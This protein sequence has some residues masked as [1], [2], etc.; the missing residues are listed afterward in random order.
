MYIGARYNDKIKLPKVETV[1]L[2]FG[3]TD[4]KGEQ[5][6]FIKTGSWSKWQRLIV[7]AIF[8]E[9]RDKVSLLQKPIGEKV[10]CFKEVLLSDEDHGNTLEI[11][12]HLAA[13]QY[14][15]SSVLSSLRFFPPHMP[16]SV[17][18][19]RGLRV[20]IYSRKDSRRRRLLN[21]D[22]VAEHLRNH[23]HIVTVIHTL[24]NL[25][26]IQQIAV[27]AY[28]DV[29][30]AP[31]GNHMVNGLFL[32][33]NAVYIECFPYSDGKRSDLG[34]IISLLQAS[35]IRFSHA[36]GTPV[37]PFV[38]ESEGTPELQNDFHVNTTELFSKLNY[39]NISA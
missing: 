1:L 15:K 17:P 28:T 24:G 35:H 18:A 32:P 21:Y 20:M 9:L 31:H 5:N 8:R 19:Q 22:E 7:F 25:D 14:L 38:P 23:G 36:P 34:Y 12:N 6:L 13:I 11:E 3:E 37:P 26:P 16:E 39:F 10:V 27:F 30:I 2:D 4:F 33:N 29:V